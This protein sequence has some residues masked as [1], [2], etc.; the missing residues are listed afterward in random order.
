MY[1]LFRALCQSRYSIISSAVQIPGQDFK[2]QT[3]IISW[4]PKKFHPNFFFLIYAESKM[5][6]NFNA[7]HAIKTSLRADQSPTETSTEAK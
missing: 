1:T 7:N 3:I 4:D 2:M 6:T 5:S